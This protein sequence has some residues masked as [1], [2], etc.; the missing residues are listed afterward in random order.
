MKCRSHLQSSS[1]LLDSLLFGYLVNLSF[2]MISPV[3][4]VLILSLTSLAAAVTPYVPANLSSLVVKDLPTTVR[5]Y[6]LPNLEGTK[7]Q[8]G[9]DVFRVLVSKAS[10]GG[11]F[12]LLGTNGQAGI[13]VP[14]H[15]HSLFY[16][17]FF[18]VKGRIRL[19]VEHEARELTPHDFGAVPPSQNH[20]YQIIDP[21]TQL[22][23]F[24]QP[25]GF[26]DFFVNVSTA[27]DPAVNGPFPPDR[28]LD[29]PAQKFVSVAPD[30]DVQITGDAAGLAYDMIN[31]TT[32]NGVWHNG[33][34]TLPGNDSTP[35]YIASNYGPKYL[36]HKLGQV[37][38]PRATLAETGGNFTISTIVMRQKQS[39]QTITPQSFPGSH[40]LQV[41]EGELTLTMAGE[42]NR[43]TTGDV[44]FV[45]GN[46]TFSYW[47]EVLY[48][49]IYAA[50]IGGG[51]TT[52]L[53]NES[54]E[55]NSAVF[56][57][58]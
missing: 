27:Y 48:T 9:D 8:L 40:A 45:P 51:L 17:T 23:G 16:E 56:P 10:S 28:S 12:T 32:D 47:S 18:L 26:E 6:I 44:A 52:K 33:N 7:L 57:S 41:L 2:K 15:Y 42:T 53:I 34:N 11:A 50:A 38:A 4:S 21:D 35:Y 43:L 54:V 31:G 30:Y 29:F 25:G 1:S 58:Y 13:Q 3:S 20:S 55:W 36:Q 5:P 37:V 46:T 24:I 39:N 22:T 19:W 14:A 49:K